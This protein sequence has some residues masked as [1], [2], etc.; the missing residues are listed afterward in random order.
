MILKYI[1]KKFRRPLPQF[2]FSLRA[3]THVFKPEYLVQINW[4]PEH[5]N[6]VSVWS[7]VT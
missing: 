3:K 5:V 1:A 4:Q 2:Y 7:V 6:P